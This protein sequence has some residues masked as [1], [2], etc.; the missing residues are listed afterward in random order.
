MMADEEEKKP[1]FNNLNEETIRAIN[2]Y[3]L[4]LPLLKVLAMDGANQQIIEVEKARLNTIH[5][6]DHHVYKIYFFDDLLKREDKVLDVLNEYAVSTLA[7]QHN[8]QHVVHLESFHLAPNHVGFLF[9]KYEIDL[10]TFLEDQQDA[11]HIQ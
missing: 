7:K 3:A 10:R 8:L 9:P 2:T 4:K 6:I 11:R 5:Y 1:N